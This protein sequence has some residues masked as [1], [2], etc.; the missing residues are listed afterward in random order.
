MREKPYLFALNGGEVSPLAMGRVDL[1]R[2]RLSGE[3]CLNIIPRVIGPIQGRPGFGHLGSTDGDGIGKNIPFIFSAT[4]TAKIELSDLKM[5]VWVDDTLVSRTSVA[6]VVMNG[7]MTATTGWTLSASGTGV[8]DINNNTGN[9]AVG[10]MTLQTP[11]RGDVVSA[12][13]SDTVSGGD[14]GVEHA[15][16]ITIDRGPVRF[17]CGSTSGGQEYIGDTELE[18]GFHSLAFTPTSSPY[19]IKFS[20][21]SEAER[22]VSN[23]A[24]ASSGAMEIVTPW[25]EDDLFTLRYD[26]SGD[27]I[28]VASSLKTYQPQ[29]IIRYGTTAWSLVPF[30]FKDGPF[31]G[32]TADVSLTPS[33]RTGNGTL[34]ASAAFFDAGHVGCV[35]RLTHQRTTV[36]ATI[37]DEDRYTDSIR[38]S[39]NAKYDAN[40]GGSDIQTEE[41]DVA[42]ALSGTWVGQVS[43]EVSYDE[44]AT[45][46][47]LE[48]DSS[49]VTAT[50]TPGY[51]NS[52]AYTRMGFSAGDYTS[53]AAVCSLTYQ[54]GGGDGYVVITGV[55]NSTSATYE[56][57]SRLHL[58]DTTNDWSEALFST[59]RGWPSAVGLFEG[60]L[61]WGG[62]DKI[63]GSLSDG[64]GSYDL[65]EEGDGGP[66]IRSI[67]T[68]PVNAVRWIM[69]LARLCI[70]TS[71]SEPVGR[72]SSFD[73]PVTPTNFSLKDAS[74]QGSADV[75]PVKVDKTAVFIQRSGKRAYSLSYSLDAQ[76][77]GATEL[78][79]YHPTILDAGVKVIA[80]QRQ[81]DT[82][83][84]FVLDD[85]TMA[86]LIME[87]QEDV[88]SWYRITTD[89]TFEDV[90]VLPNT[91]DDDVHV[92]VNRTINGATKRY[93]EKL[94]YDHQ[95]Q[96]AAEH[97]MADS[98]KTVTLSA[99]DTVTGADHLEGETVVVW[100][101]GVALMTDD[102]PSTFT[103]TSGSFTLPEA[104][105][106]DVTYGLSYDWQWQS[107]KLA[108]GVQD[109][110]PISRRKK[111]SQVAPVLYKTH[112]RGITYG[113]NFTDMAYLP[114]IDNIDGSTNTTSKV[115][116]A[117]DP[118]HQSL[119]GVWDTDSRI[120]L[121]GTAPLPCTILAL[122][123]VV[124]AN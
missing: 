124:D 107:A 42:K 28:Y 32:K 70:G 63:V 123:L 99:S 101:D 18:T 57:I 31:R 80:V 2:M 37:T 12:S 78:S 100:A 6:T 90:I 13:R 109:G 3:T 54:G 104:V 29:K 50:I 52:I 30:E 75:Q 39:G 7:D 95:A 92:I 33:A 9:G 23:V 43:I 96:G 53:G 24:I 71:G 4:D 84:L 10:V 94:A 115:Y 77:Y 14:Q 44:E 68:G 93:H 64:F 35:F 66:I 19:Y 59:L 73:E 110:N 38:V 60:R 51:A 20:T 117:Y 47:R 87:P 62:G 25:S 118:D 40:S 106:G 48:D 16:E 119:P 113:Y 27:V 103:V 88:L 105:T 91:D 116:D 26:Q 114:L 74:T 22:V 79:R 82:R 102:A 1:S 112:I 67:A 69:G 41:R 120:C 65:N 97:F 108:Y 15:I 98:Y 56:V 46:L 58:S 89:G 36:S 76:D 122:S 72:S 45:W 83:I 8:A 111:V 61:W 55:T 86:C 34:T 17:R 21:E 121:A 49:N 5:R 81:P 85:G 11:G